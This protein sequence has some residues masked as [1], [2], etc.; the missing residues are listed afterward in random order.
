MLESQL[1]P[2]LSRV[3]PVGGRSSVRL[4]GVGGVGGSVL[5]R[6]HAVVRAIGL[7][8][9][10]RCVLLL[11]LLRDLRHPGGSVRHLWSTPC[12]QVRMTENA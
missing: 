4:E 5:L 8:V 2:H 7:P 10:G 11:L 1:R 3:T 9:H 6:R 12:T